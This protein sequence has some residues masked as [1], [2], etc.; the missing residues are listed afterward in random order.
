LFAGT[1]GYLFPKRKLYRGR[2]SLGGLRE[3]PLLTLVG[4]LLVVLF[5][6][7]GF[8]ATRQP[9]VTVTPPPT[10]K[11]DLAIVGMRFSPAKPAPGEV[12][13][14][15]LQIR[16]QGDAPSGPFQWTFYTQD[17]TQGN[18]LPA[19]TGTVANV[20]PGITHVARSE[21]VFGGW[22]AFLTTAFVNETLI[23]PE[24]SIVNNSIT[25]ALTT[26]ISRPF[27]IDFQ[28]LSTGAEVLEQT[29]LSGNEFDEWRMKFSPVITDQACAG[30]VL[31]I[32]LAGEDGER[33][34]LSTGLKGQPTGCESLPIRIGLGQP[35]SDLAAG[36]GSVQILPSKVGVYRVR[37][38]DASAQTELVVSTKTVTE[39]QLDQPLEIPITLP[40]QSA[41]S[42]LSNTIIEIS[43][44]L[45]APLV[46]LIVTLEPAP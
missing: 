6:I 27:S 12:V 11:I 28:F 16:N 25:R 40:K 41:Q 18:I 20:S 8:V 17:P 14:I 38:L 21:F 43:P 22:G 10:G 31:R 45:E 23:T 37:V 3:S 13:R 7:G 36:S 42:T 9:V 2:P 32:T 34:Q 15:T 4:L 19:L 26:D 24:T 39:A 46:L 35:I 1:H 33:R 29:D 44:P 5:A 30:A